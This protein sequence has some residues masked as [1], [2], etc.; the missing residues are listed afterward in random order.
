MCIVSSLIND[1][2]SLFYHSV[3]KIKKLCH[4]GRN[5]VQVI[6]FGQTMGRGA[7]SFTNFFSVK[8]LTEF[9]DLAGLLLEQFFKGS[10]LLM[11]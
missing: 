10:A 2:I 4:W 9:L 5:G 3:D 7:Q 6:F 1:I 8:I 11:F